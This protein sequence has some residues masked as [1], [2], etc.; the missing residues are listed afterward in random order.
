MRSSIAV[1][2]G[3]STEF[4][5]RRDYPDKSQCYE[6]GEEGHLSYQCEKNTLGVRTPPPKKVRIRNKNK[7]KGEMDNSYYDSDSEDDTKKHKSAYGGYDSD[8][9]D[10]DLDTL[11][12]AIKQ[13]VSS[14]ILVLII[15]LF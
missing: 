7:E 2:N 14:D 10:A 8:A 3:R 1:D 9:P 6:C 12:S 4:I 13:E 5:R 15:K 11:S